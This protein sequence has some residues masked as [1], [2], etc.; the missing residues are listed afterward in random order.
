MIHIHFIRI[1]TATALLLL[2]PLIAMQFTAEVVWDLTD[3]IVAGILLFITGL[4]I[5][6]VLQ[7]FSNTSHRILVVGIVL[8]IF[9]LT[10]AEL[11]V[12]IF[13]TPWAGS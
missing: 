6:F 4:L 8:L 3:F 2:I 1:T 5:D 9:I 11:A 12:G 7:K 13:G 10:W